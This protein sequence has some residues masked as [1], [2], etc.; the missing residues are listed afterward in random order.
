MDSFL[1]PS[2]LCC[3]PSCL[4]VLS[5]HPLGSRVACSGL[6]PFALLLVKLAAFAVLA[7][8]ALLAEKLSLPQSYVH[9]VEDM[10]QVRMQ[11]EEA[12]RNTHSDTLLGGGGGNPVP[13]VLYSPARPG[14]VELSNPGEV[15]FVQALRSNGMSCACALTH[16]VS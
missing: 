6:P 1:L 3:A 12:M 13:P 8:S 5:Y 11:I 4:S 9:P 15:S 16:V 7:V 14:A 10:E 2:M